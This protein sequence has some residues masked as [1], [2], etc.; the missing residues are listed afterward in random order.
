MTLGFWDDPKS[1]STLLAIAHDPTRPRDVRDEAL[2][3]LARLEAPEAIETLGEAMADPRVDEITRCKCADALGEIGNP[4]ALPALEALAKGEPP[5]QVREA[6][7]R[8]IESIG[9]PT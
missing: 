8:A 2:E 4:A 9:R 7:R 3:A 5:R 1:V 6:V